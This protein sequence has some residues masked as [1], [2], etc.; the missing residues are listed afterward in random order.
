[1]IAINFDNLYRFLMHMF[2]NWMGQHPKILKIK[3]EKGFTSVQYTTQFDVHIV[4]IY[5]LKYSLFWKT[6]IPSYVQQ[7]II[8]MLCPK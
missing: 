1:M 3:Y 2:H 4:D 6:N 8:L 5:N 7:L